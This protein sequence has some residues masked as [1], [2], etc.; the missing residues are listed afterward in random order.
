MVGGQVFFT[1]KVVGIGEVAE[2]CR[3]MTG[4]SKL[5]CFSTKSPLNLRS[6][7]LTAI[8]HSI[9]RLISIAIRLIVFVWKITDCM[10]VHSAILPESVLK[11]LE[12]V[13]K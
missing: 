2:Y 3:K 7:S 4:R 6:T 12:N 10:T 5:F 13:R 1:E 11:K 8:H 9:D